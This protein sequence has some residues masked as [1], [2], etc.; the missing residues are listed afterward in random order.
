VPYCITQFSYNTLGGGLGL[1][2]AISSLRVSRSHTER[3]ATRHA[4]LA[5]AAAAGSALAYPTLAVLFPVHL[6]ILVVFGRTH[7][8]ALRIG[9]RFALGATLVGLYVGAFLLRSG[10]GSL[11]LT[12][13]FIRAWG[14]ALSNTAAAVV[15]GL[16]A[17]KTNWFSSLAI[18]AAI[19][20]LATRFRAAVLLLAIAVPFLAAPT[21][22][23][24]VADS[25]RFYSCCAIFA[26]FFAPL[27]RDKKGAF[28]L[29][30]ILWAPGMLTGFVMGY[31]SGNI[32][33]ACGLGGFAGMLAGVLLAC[34]ACEEAMGRFRFFAAP[35]GS[36]APLALLWALTGRVLA[37]YAAY[38]D[39]APT[40]L[41]ARVRT[42]PFLGLKT[43]EH[44]RERVEHMHRDIVENARGPFVLF[45]PDLPSGYLSANARAAIPEVWPSGVV[46]RSE[47][48]AQ[49]Y[50][51]RLPNVGFVMVQRCEVVRNWQRWEECT[52]ELDIPADPLQA[53]VLATHV[54]AFRHFGYSVWKRR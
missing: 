52:P 51:E 30:A 22:P 9:A 47:I 36:V 18:A 39:G 13:T 12:L 5:G 45:L 17:M 29:L 16:N 20:V 40:A 14:P 28:R 19:T 44:R 6:T 33:N 50:R 38:R 35:A 15:D 49:I 48:D 43:T 34:R 54:E 4:I 37:P 10:I 26:P 32:W 27:V 46:S 41:E 8:G 21:T 3:E 2:A 7:V 42:G 24:D 23:P 11:A 25:M 31:S 53:A 1:L